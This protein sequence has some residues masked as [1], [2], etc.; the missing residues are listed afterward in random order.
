MVPWEEEYEAT[1]GKMLRGPEAP[2]WPGA[3]L[4][5]SH[6]LVRWHWDPKAFSSSQSFRSKKISLFLGAKDPVP[7]QPSLPRSQVCPRSCVISP[8][9]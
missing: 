7:E 2:G 8:S 9:P 5:P 6:Q 3:T 4:R 1:V